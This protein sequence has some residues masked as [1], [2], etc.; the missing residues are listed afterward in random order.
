MSCG[1]S[2]PPFLL[3]RPFRPLFRWPRPLPSPFPTSA[4]KAFFPFLYFH[5]DVTHER[6]A[7]GIWCTGIWG[8]EGEKGG[9]P[10]DAY[11]A[12][13]RARDLRKEMIM[14]SLSS[15]SEMQVVFMRWREEAGPILSSGA[16]LCGSGIGVRANVCIYSSFK[17]PVELQTAGARANCI[18]FLCPTLP[19][20]VS[21]SNIY[22]FKKSTRL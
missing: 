7:K 4:Q 12:G 14:W 13:D 21:V 20:I 6:A 2:K 19:F 15:P 11:A 10:C 17:T 16:M 3:S 1:G 8:M 18:A 22:F 5:A 9:S